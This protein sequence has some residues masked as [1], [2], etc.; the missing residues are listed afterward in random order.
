[1]AR[2]IKRNFKKI[3]M[4]DGNFNVTSTFGSSGFSIDTGYQTSTTTAG[5]YNITIGS[6]ADG[7]TTTFTG[8]MSAYSERQRKEKWEKLVETLGKL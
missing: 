8:A 7:F 1:M 6:T 5:S 3:I 4:G 2:S